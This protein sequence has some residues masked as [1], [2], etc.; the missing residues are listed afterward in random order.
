MAIKKTDVATGQASMKQV[1]DAAG[2]AVSTVSRALANPGRVNEK[3][4]KR[5]LEAAQTL[6]YTPNAAARS[7]RKGRTG[8]IMIVLPGQL[9]H[10]ASQVIPLVL[11]GI[12]RF[13]AAHGYNI[14]I[15][16][17]DR[18]ESSE[19]HIVNL[20]SNG[21]VDGAII[22][23]SGIPQ[24]SQKSL[25]Q[26]GL[27]IISAL[28]DLS[29]HG[30]PS[31]ITNESEVMG[32]MTELLAQQGHRQ[33]FYVAGPQGMY[34]ER[35]RLDGIRQGIAQAD[36]PAGS[37]RKSQGLRPYQEGF[38]IGVDA[39]DMFLDF[40]QRPT[41]VMCC[42]DDAALSFIAKLTTSGLR[43]PEDVC[44]VGFDGSAVG[45]FVNPSL[46]TIAQPAEAIGSKVAE[47]LTRQLDGEHVPMVTQL[48]SAIVRRQSA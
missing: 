4:R 47:L 28:H 9:F 34:H 2:V 19:A 25:T 32:K 37:L 42:S 40:A 29:H 11:A 39:A 27:P 43:V 17:L 14:L 21:S 24:T 46:T 33:F 31:V 30:I 3:T 36:L 12:D 22:I 41:A 10:G 48:D 13:L 23:S 1:A 35:V 6:G 7:L 45:A 5:I 44:V 8:A 20:A 38:Q 26:T 15:A 16:N 18:D